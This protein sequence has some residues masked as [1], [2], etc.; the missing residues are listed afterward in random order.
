MP[1]TLTRVRKALGL[2]DT[3]DLGR[4]FEDRFTPEQHLRANSAL[5]SIETDVIMGKKDEAAIT[6]TATLL[7]RGV[8]RMHWADA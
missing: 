5:G 7:L 8:N 2:P 1:K 6:A 4:S 3:H